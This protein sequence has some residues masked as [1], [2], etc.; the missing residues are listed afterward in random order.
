MIWS[1]S[2]PRF[3]HSCWRAIWDISSTIS[4]WTWFWW[5]VKSTSTLATVCGFSC[6]QIETR[7]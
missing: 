2:F 4:C 5:R 7:N 3:V 6:K 1:S